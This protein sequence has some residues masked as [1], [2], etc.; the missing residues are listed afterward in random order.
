ML[1]VDGRHTCLVIGQEKHRLL[2]TTS[3]WILSMDLVLFFLTF[4]GEF[5]EINF[6]APALKVKS[7][8]HT[9]AAN[10]SLSA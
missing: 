2:S 5:A 1:L 7:P 3:E 10:N 8:R 4:C 6:D 9:H